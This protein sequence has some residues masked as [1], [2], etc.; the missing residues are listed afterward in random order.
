MQNAKAIP[1]EFEHALV[2]AVMDE[3]KMRN[4]VRKTCA[5]R[6]KI[7][8]LKGVKIRKRFE[9]KVNK[10]VDVGMPNLWGHFKDEVL[11]A[12]DEVCGKR[13]GRRCEGDTWWWNE[14]VK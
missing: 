9:G 11:M 7:T 14:E 13:R 10:F 12:C 6:G 1:G 3:R 8:L 4:V 2:I 5:E